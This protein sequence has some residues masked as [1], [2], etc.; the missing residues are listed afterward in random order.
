MNQTKHGVA[1]RNQRGFAQA[2]V[3]LICAYGA[4]RGD[5]IILTQ[6]VAIARLVEARAEIAALNRALDT[7]CSDLFGVLRQLNDVE[8]EIPVLMKLIDKHGGVVVVIGDTL[9]T[10]YG[11]H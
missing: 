10:V 3:K 1:R 9:I 2:E 8:A 4:D 5:K 6:K 7:G 11:L